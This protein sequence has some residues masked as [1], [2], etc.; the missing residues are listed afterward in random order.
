MGAILRAAFD[1]TAPTGSDLHKHLACQAVPHMN[2][3]P[4]KWRLT[5]VGFQGKPPAKKPE[6]R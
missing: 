5:G 1:C 3:I 6:T 4:P 2:Q